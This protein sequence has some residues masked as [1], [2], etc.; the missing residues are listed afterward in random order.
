[1]FWHKNNNLEDISGH[2][3]SFKRTVQ[4]MTCAQST[5]IQLKSDHGW[6]TSFE[7]FFC[8][9]H[10]KKHP[11]YHVIYSPFHKMR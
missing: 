5:A 1:M 10:F 7:Y 8:L 4:V 11:K 3:N 9:S 6:I 2:Q